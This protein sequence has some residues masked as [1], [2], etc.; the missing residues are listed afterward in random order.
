M[1]LDND[2]GRLTSHALHLDCYIVLNFLQTLIGQLPCL[3]FLRAR[4]PPF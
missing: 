1:F 3:S 2:A 4:S